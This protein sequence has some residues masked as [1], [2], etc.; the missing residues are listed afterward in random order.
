MSDEEPTL[1]Q[2]AIAAIDALSATFPD[3]EEVALGRASLP[4]WMG[5]P[6]LGSLT[7]PADPKF[8]SSVIKAE[9]WLATH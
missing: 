6:W 7:D 5:E 9:A 3:P 4:D 8:A 2:R 1:E